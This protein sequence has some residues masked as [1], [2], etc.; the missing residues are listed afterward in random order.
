LLQIT[1]HSG[2]GIGNI[3]DIA[4]K[5]LG[6]SRIKSG[7]P[8]ALVGF[9]GSFRWCQWADLFRHF[10]DGCL[11][12]PVANGFLAQH[13]LISKSIVAFDVFFL[14]SP[15]SS[16]AISVKKL[17]HPWMKVGGI[18]PDRWSVACD[19]FWLPFPDS[20]RYTDNN[21]QMTFVLV[22]VL[23]LTGIVFSMTGC[24]GGAEKG[25]SSVK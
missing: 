16:Q 6:K 24:S 3:G 12:N 22:S 1:K 18:I 14:G 10:S 15:W 4:S 11:T 19:D 21:F 7:V 2:E 20:Q 13:S 25:M 23:C 9:L 8:R 5:K 17:G